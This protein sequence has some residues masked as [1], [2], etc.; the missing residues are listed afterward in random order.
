[1]AKKSGIETPTKA[2]LARMDRKRKKR[3]SNQDWVN[4]ND[5][6]ARVTKMKDGSTHMAHKAEH[7]VDMETGAIV[8]ITLQ[9][10]DQGDTKT[11]RQTLAEAGE[12]TAGV[13]AEVNTAAAELVNPEG[14]EE[15]VTDKGYHSNAV[16]VDLGKA[17][18]RSY[19]AEADRGK[20]NW[21]GKAEEKT[22]VYGNRRRVKG[23]RGK[24]L[25]EQRGEKLE[26]P[27]AH[28][29]ETGGMRRTH[30]RGHGNILKRL[31]VHGAGCNLGL[32]MRNQ[33]GAGK[34]R[35]LQGRPT[36]SFSSIWAG[37]W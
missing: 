34:P 18:A 20:R 8:A 32:L 22:A 9:G 25:L 4:P 36:P 1:M 11:I 14:P 21:E 28:M 29:Y 30:L 12:N 26:R 27:F 35:V 19:I 31:L 24:K 2:E 16:L 17:E 23:K 15:V 37:K 6:D 7:A 3:T 33:G 5:P 10:A 13:A